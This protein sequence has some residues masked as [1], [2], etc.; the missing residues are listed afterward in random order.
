MKSTQAALKSRGFLEKQDKLSSSELSFE[1]K[2]MLLQSSIAVERTL[3]ARLL[4]SENK[5]KAIPLLIEA[6]KTEKKLY[7]KIEICN[8]LISF[9]LPAVKP[10]IGQ[11]GKIGNNQHKIIPQE[12]FNKKSYPLPR[13][14]SAR[15]LANMGAI[16]LPHLL[17]T[18]HTEN[19]SQLSEA[20]DS[21][22]YI[23][24]YD[25][26][27]HVFEKLIL[28]F[29]ENKANE[30]I[31]WKIMRAMSAFP[32]S[33]SFLTEQLQTEKNAGIVLEIERSVFSF[34]LSQKRSVF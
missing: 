33:K 6:L 16:A 27:E 17:E 25:Y 12:K 15:T 29:E 11:L 26:Q 3:G 14:I 4:S 5:E 13:D 21:I 30:L 23:C 28:C 19:R 7:S 31:R 8:T 10:L 1:E 9:G 2:I 34:D 20:I 24:F 18:L 32:E 22:G